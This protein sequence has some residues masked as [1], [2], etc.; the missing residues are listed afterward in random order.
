MGPSGKTASQ[1]EIGSAKHAPKALGQGLPACE[2][3]LDS[4]AS[5]DHISVEGRNE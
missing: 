4:T 1:Q 2:T 5:G 3:Q